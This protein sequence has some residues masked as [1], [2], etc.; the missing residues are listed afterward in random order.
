LRM[1]SLS[2]MM[3]MAK[4]D[5]CVVEHVTELSDCMVV[6]TVLGLQAVPSR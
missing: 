1:A 6:V 2:S 4:S 5:R 3:A